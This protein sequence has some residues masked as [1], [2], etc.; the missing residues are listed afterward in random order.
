[1]VS[2]S[3]GGLRLTS[4]QRKYLE[5]QL[6][7]V[8]RSFAILIP[9][10][11]PPVRFYL[12]A[13]Y[14]LCRVADN[15]EDC[16]RPHTWKKERF[17]EFLQLLQEPQRAA[18]QLAAWDQLP[19]PALTQE[20]RLMMGVSN[21]LPLWQIYA[22]IPGQAQL[23]VKRWISVMATGMSQLGEPHTRPSFVTRKGIDVLAELKDATTYA[24]ALPQRAAGYRRESLLYLFSSYHT[25]FSAAQRQHT[26][27]TSSH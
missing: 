5:Q 18:K 23:V 1:M 4:T 26:L 12:A 10:V 15:I 27:F 3:T 24:L 11:D 9:F 25:M 19:W 22:T 8:S 16:G 21:G 20:E 7:N 13:A 2:D 14:L 6:D 17:Q